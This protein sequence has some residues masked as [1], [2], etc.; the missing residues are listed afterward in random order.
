LL[1]TNTVAR[2]LP[3]HIFEISE[4]DRKILDEHQLHYTVLSIPEPSGSD[5]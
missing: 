5:Q 3:G 4:R 1:A 2:R